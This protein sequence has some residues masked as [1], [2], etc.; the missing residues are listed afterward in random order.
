[1]FLRLC[2][3]R[4]VSPRLPAAVCLVL[5]AGAFLETP[6]FAQPEAMGAGSAFLDIDNDGDLDVFYLT[7]GGG[8]VMM[9]NEN[10]TSFTDVSTQAIPNG[11]RISGNPATGVA[12]ADLNNDGSTD[13][14][15]GMNGPNYLLLNDGQGVFRGVAGIAGAKGGFVLTGS[16]AIFD[17]DR[18]GLLDIYVANYEGNEN[19]FYHATMIDGDGV[20][21]YQDVAPALGMDWA[22]N[23]QSDW[24]LG[25]LAFDYDNDG[26]TD[27]YLANDYNGGSSG[28][29]LEPGDNILYRNE[30][31]GTFADVSDASGTRDQGWAMGAAHGDFDGDG[32]LDIFVA[33]FWE[34]VLYRNNHDGTF[35]DISAEVGLQN[36]PLYYNGWGT[37]LF[38]FDNDG[39]LDIHVANGYIT[40]GEGQVEDEPDQL[41][42]NV[43]LDGKLRFIERTNQ[44]GVNQIADSRGAAY[45]DYNQDGFIDI[46]VVNNDYVSSAGQNATLPLRCFFVNQRDGTFRDRAQALGFRTSV[47]DPGKPPGYKDTQ[48]FHWLDVLSKGTISNRSAIGSRVTVR[49]GDRTW[50]QDVGASSYLSSNSPY[51]HFGLGTATVVDEVT[52]RFPSGHVS[53]LTDVAVDQR[54]TVVE[55]PTPVRLAAFSVTG[56]AE[57]VAVAWRYTDDGEGP[58]FRVARDDGGVT[59]LVSDWM[60]ARQGTG[61]VLDADPPRGRLLTYRLVVRLRDGSIETLASREIRLPVLPGVSVGAASPNPF[62][63]SIGIAVTSAQGGAVSLEILDVTGRLVRTV[64]QTLSPGQSMIPWDG[65]DDSGRP[66]PAGTYFYRLRGESQARR[67][68][69]LP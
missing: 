19:Y 64:H 26:D 41:W 23:G 13:L 62:R 33:N 4:G 48:S 40:N 43:V 56:E 66:A 61:R 50:I 39:D 60:E 11:V 59:V 35:T 12:A 32:W 58:R 54:V 29:R 44:A 65:Q 8:M 5:G 28:E 31:D 22:P 47:P 45:G 51:L 36:Q 15:I 55:D 53:R 14:F 3:V 52:V 34:D 17:Y 57:G 21:H 2:R 46:L 7:P 49:A 6:A 24:T 1:M 9:R 25:L 68:V 38:D 63:G 42:E 30:G 10:G 69:I 16:I 27:L 37:A 67:M 20:P 18:D